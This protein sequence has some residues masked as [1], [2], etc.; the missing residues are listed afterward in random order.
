M[1]ILGIFM[2]YGF[3]RILYCVLREFKQDNCFW[4]ISWA[5]L[6]IVNLIGALYFLGYKDYLLKIKYQHLEIYY[7][8]IGVIIFTFFYGGYKK[9]LTIDDV[10]KRR[11]MNMELRSVFIALVIAIILS[12]Y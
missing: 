3:V 6:S 7:I 9:N 10:K 1:I 2:L 11:K 8:F 4:R 12:I 5:L